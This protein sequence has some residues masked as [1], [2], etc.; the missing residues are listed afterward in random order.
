MTDWTKAEVEYV[1][2]DMSLRELAEK[3]GESYSTLSKAAA[4]GKWTAKRKEFRKKAATNALAR[5]QRRT[6]NKLDRLLQSSEKVLNTAITAIED[7]KQFN[8][9]IVTGS[10][11]E[12]EERTF[13]K[14]DTRAMKEMTAVI[15]ELT[16]LLRDF[17]DVPTPAQSAARKIAKERLALE[18][19]KTESRDG[20]RQIEVVLQAGPE[21]WNE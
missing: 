21:E 6:E 9:Y 19:K 8:R 20:I 3:L 10:S 17:Y 5:A 7:D 18:K 4:D 15:R 12:A 1:A 13:D 16:G 11:G 14:V 2:G